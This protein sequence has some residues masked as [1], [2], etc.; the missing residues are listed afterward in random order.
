MP[1]QHKESFLTKLQKNNRVQIPTMIRQ[2]HKLKAGDI[3]Y[4]NVSL[5]DSLGTRAFYARLGENCR[6]T[7][8]RN[9]VN[10]M[11]MEPGDQL[12]VALL[13]AVMPSQTRE[14]GS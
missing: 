10:Y 12:H 4:V 13:R 5:V 2:I 11:K 14:K 7:V 8:P 9:V 1:L 6:F 3:L